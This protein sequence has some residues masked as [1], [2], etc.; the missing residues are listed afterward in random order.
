[1]NTP[2]GIRN[3][4]PLN[5]RRTQ[6]HWLGMC[7]Q[8]TDASFC[9]FS[10]MRY[11]IRA[12][13][14]VIKTYVCR[15]NCR[16]V[17]DIIHRWAPPSDGNNTGKYV[18]TVCNG[19]TFLTPT[20]IIDPDNDEQLTHL[21]QRMAFVECGYIIPYETVRQGVQMRKQYSL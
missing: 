1:M 21:L 10:D 2:R 16:T 11:G 8:Q 4:N 6:I 19:S 15:Y 13:A 12:A 14:R 7:E 9:Q 3:K 5:I 17:Q 18:R 20:T